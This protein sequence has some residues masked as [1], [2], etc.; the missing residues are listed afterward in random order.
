MRVKK[1][2]NYER[3]LRLYLDVDHLSLSE[4]QSAGFFEMGSAARTASTAEMLGL[5]PVVAH[6]ILSAFGGQMR[7]VKREGKAGCLEVILIREQGYAKQNT[8]KN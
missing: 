2:H 7:L 1:N 5:A 8:K 3:A 6:N 4:E